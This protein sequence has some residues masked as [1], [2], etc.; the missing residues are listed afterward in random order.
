MHVEPITTGGQ[1]GMIGSRRQLHVAVAHFS[2]TTA[3][4]GRRFSWETPIRPLSPE[5]TLDAI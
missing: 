5:F 4:Q 3:F 1:G 2:N